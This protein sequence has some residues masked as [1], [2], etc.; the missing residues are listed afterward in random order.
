MLK[1]SDQQGA[2]L[3]PKFLAIPYL[4]R[5]RTFHGADCYG[6]IILWYKECLGIDLL[7]VEEEYAPTSNWKGRGLFL[8]HYH[9]QW[10]RVESPG[11][12]DVAIFRR[13]GR[14]DHVGVYLMRGR[15]LHMMKAGA[16]VG[17][18]ANPMWGQ[19]L[20]GFYHLRGRSE[21]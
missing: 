6:M 11:L 7:D 12:Y 9:L 16:A 1:L 13:H 2:Q 3:L 8:E 14:C 15:F 20:E 10:E 5:G 18:M 19:S 21:G 17:D 4:H